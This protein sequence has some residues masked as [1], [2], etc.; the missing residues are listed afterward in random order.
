MSAPL[1]MNPAIRARWTAKLRSGEIPQAT[2]VLRDGNA[3]C[4]FG[5]LCDLAVE[6]G[7]ITLSRD[8]GRW[9][10]DFRDKYVSEEVRAWAGLIN[11]NPKVT[12]GRRH[13]AL[14]WHNDN[15]ATFAQ[16]ADAIDGTQVT[17]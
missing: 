4:C 13:S 6:D 10:Y 11:F 5:V 9:L 17:P 8:D 12:I 2:G 14:A 15:G 7:V 3:R 1:E 16:I